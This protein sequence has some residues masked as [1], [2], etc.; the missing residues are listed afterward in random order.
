M[1]DLV[2]THY[3]ARPQ[4]AKLLNECRYITYLCSVRRIRPRYLH[5]PRRRLWFG[6]TTKSVLE[7]REHARRFYVHTPRIAPYRPLLRVR[8]RCAMAT[9]RTHSPG[10]RSAEEETLY[11]ETQLASGGYNTARILKRPEHP[12]MMPAARSSLSR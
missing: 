8:Q 9:N 5:R 4:N 12:E 11:Y 3:Y 10:F 2:N 1:T 6:P 7:R